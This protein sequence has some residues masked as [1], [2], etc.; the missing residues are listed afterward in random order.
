MCAGGSSPGIGP[1]APA[2]A[3]RPRREETWGS[4]LG[5]GRRGSEPAPPSPS[6]GS[7]GIPKASPGPSSGVRD[8]RG[9]RHPGEWCS[10][11]PTT[12]ETT[13][14]SPS[15]RRRPR[16][17]PQQAP[18]AAPA[19][20]R[21]PCR[22]R[23]GTLRHGL[24]GGSSGWVGGGAHDSW[25]GNL[26]PSLHAGGPH[27]GYHGHYHDEGYGPPPPHYEGRRMGP[28]VGGHRR[29]PSRYGPQYGHPPPPPPPPEYGPHADSPVLMVYGL[30]QSKMN[31]DRVFNIF[32]LYGNVEKVNGGGLP[33]EDGVL[34]VWAWR[35]GDHLF[36][37]FPSR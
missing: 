35:W 33:L 7:W 13:L 10:P 28:P 32:C 37:C 23:Y 34:Q 21:P 24:K 17:Q 4:R 19:P 29:G 27:G 25:G 31:C 1:L 8:W 30:D 9:P 2:R 18:A 5:A 14:T 6:W 16:W 26:Q 11:L 20:G 3:L 15:T 36:H 22:V 12:T